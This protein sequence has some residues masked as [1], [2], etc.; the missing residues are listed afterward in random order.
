MSIKIKEVIIVSKKIGTDLLMKI[1][2]SDWIELTNNL[3]GRIDR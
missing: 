1:K 3:A 2:C